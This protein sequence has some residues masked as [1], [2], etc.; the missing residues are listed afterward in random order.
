VAEYLDLIGR[1]RKARPDIALSCD[2]IVGFPGETEEDF[3]DTLELCQKVRY[4]QAYSFKYSQRPGTPASD[5]A[6]VDEVEKSDRLARLQA[7]LSEH[8]MDFQ[9]SMI[10]KTLPVLLEKP[11]RMDGQM[12]GKSE[13]LHAVHMNASP[14]LVGS[15][16]QAKVLH[17]ERNSLAAEIVR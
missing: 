15:I 6:E 7:L 3:Q 4:A 1:I 2:F 9:R 11:G 12:V 14:S 13:F 5:L 16:V 10:G 8:Q 17:S